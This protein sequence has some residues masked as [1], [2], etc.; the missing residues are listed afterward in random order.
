MRDEQKTKAQLMEE[1]SSLRQEL[2]ALKSILGKQGVTNDA[3]SMPFPQPLPSTLDK[4]EIVW[5]VEDALMT[6]LDEFGQPE[7]P[8]DV[9]NHK[10][11]EYLGP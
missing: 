2:M 6:G 7:R 3:T 11:S 5:N 8:T 4:S 9:S 1:L 10:G